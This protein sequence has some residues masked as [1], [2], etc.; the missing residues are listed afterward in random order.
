MSVR[1]AGTDPPAKSVSDIAKYFVGVSQ[2]WEFV[3][4]E[5]KEP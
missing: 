3:Q 5:V 4:D 1:L 2:I